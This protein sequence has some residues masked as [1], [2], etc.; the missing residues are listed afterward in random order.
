[1]DESAG[2]RWKAAFLNPL[3]AQT[4]AEPIARTMT[5]GGTRYSPDPTTNLNRV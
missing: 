2:R 1:M 5:G 4:S 3:K